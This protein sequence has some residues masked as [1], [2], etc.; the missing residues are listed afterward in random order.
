MKL[1]LR[2]FI[3][4]KMDKNAVFCVIVFVFVTVSGE[5]PHVADEEDFTFSIDS[6]CYHYIE[7]R[8]SRQV[9][10]AVAESDCKS[11]G[12]HLLTI[13]DNNTQQ[14][15]LKQDRL[16]KVSQSHTIVIGLRKSGSGWQWTSGL[17][18]TFFNW[19]T[20]SHSTGEC[21]RM[22]LQ[23]GGTWE[24]YDCSTTEWYLAYVCEYDPNAS[25]FL[26]LGQSWAI[27]MLTT[28]CSALAMAFH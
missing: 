12:G 4:M 20:K 6:I 22:V 15:L 8:D 27:I 7:P 5:C 19:N 13:K 1:Y 28:M 2:N 26:P 16:G 24:K 25:G 14:E 17:K 18:A 10:F 3:I 23:N 9:F 11:R 21:T